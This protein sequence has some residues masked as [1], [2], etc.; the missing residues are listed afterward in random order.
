MTRFGGRAFSR[1]S[2]NRQRLLLDH[3]G[4]L[5]EGIERMLDAALARQDEAA[6]QIMS[7]HVNK[8]HV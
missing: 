7:P 6:A 8:R 1:P 4:D 2:P 5:R 3:H